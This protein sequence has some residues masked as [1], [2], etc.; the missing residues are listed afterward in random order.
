MRD[1]G[2][3]DVQEFFDRIH[4]VNCVHFIDLLAALDGIELPMARTLRAVAQHQ[5]RA[6]AFCYG[7][8]EI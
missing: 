5:L 4:H 2:F 1:A 6:I 3:G 7:V 8:R